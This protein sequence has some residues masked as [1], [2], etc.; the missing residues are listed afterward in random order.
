LKWIRNLPFATIAFI[1]TNAVVYRLGLLSW[2]EPVS[3][4]RLF[5]HPFI[6]DSVAHI[7]GNIVFGIFIVGTLIES[8]MTRLKRIVRY[9]VLVYSYL[10]S[11][12]IAAI[13]WVEK[14]IV[15]IGS[16]GVILAGLAIVMWYYRI[17]HDR[18]DLKGWN[19]LGPVGLGVAFAFLAQIL[20]LGF[21]NPGETAS[22]QL[23]ASVFFLSFVIFYGADIVLKGERKAKLLQVS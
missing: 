21:L 8:W 20:V 9:G 2:V 4:E 23:H 10:V 16:S 5:L 1:G 7:T 12:V 22:V 6:H 19:A 3:I 11:L 13:W 18:L 14:G 17:F 15:P